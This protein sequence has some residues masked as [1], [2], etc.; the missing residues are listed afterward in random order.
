MWLDGVPGWVRPWIGWVVGM[1]WPQADEAKLFALADALADAAYRVAD[2]TGVTP[3]A[4]DAWDGEAFRAFVTNASARVGERQAEVLARLAAM[5]I[6]L[7]DLGVQVQYTKRMIKLSIALLVFQLATLLP[8]LANPATAGAGIA[9]AGLRARFAREIVVQVAKRLL[10]NIALF[11]GLMGGMDLYVQATQ[12]RRDAIDW[13]QVLTSAGTG[14]LNGVFLTGATWLMPPRR[15]LDLMLASGVAGGLT[16]ATIQ[17]FDDQPFDLMRLLKGVSSGAIGAADAHWASW[18]PHA[19]RPNGDGTLAAGTHGGDDAGPSGGARSGDPAL[20]GDRRDVTGQATFRHPDPAPDPAAARPVPDPGA[21]ARV[22]PDHDPAAR[23]VPEAEVRTT[24]AQHEPQPHASQDHAPRQAQPLTARQDFMVR[25]FREETS[26]GLWFRNQESTDMSVTGDMRRR[27]PLPGHFDVGIRATSDGFSVGGFSRPPADVPPGVHLVPG[28][29]VH[30]S[31]ADLA[32]VLGE[33]RRLAAQPDAALRLFGPHARHDALLLQDLADRTGRAVVAADNGMPYGSAQGYRGPLEGQWHRFEPRPPGGLHESVAGGVR[34]SRT[35]EVEDLRAEVVTFTDGVTAVRF[36]G[37]AADRAE[38]AA[39][40]ARA[41]GMDAP[42]THR[43]GESVYQS[44]GSAELARSAA[45]GIRRTDVYSFG[46][47]MREVVTFNDGTRAIR[48]EYV[49]AADADLHESSALPPFRAANE[50]SVYRA[51]ETVVYETGLLR[52]DFA[53][54]QSM[55]RHQS[56]AQRAQRALHYVLTQAETF[57]PHAVVPDGAGRHLYAVPD[58][59]TEVWAADITSELLWAHPRPDGTLGHFTVGDNLLAP[60]DFAAR[61]DALAALRPEFERLG[62]ADWHDGLMQ[63]YDLLAEHARGATPLLGAADPAASPVHQAPEPRWLQRDPDPADAR[64]AV[65]DVLDGDG[66]R[67]L[68]ETLADRWA[69]PADVARAEAYAQLADQHLAAGLHRQE[70]VHARVPI[71][72][73]PSDMLPGSTVTFRG[74]LEGVTEP[75]HLP[76]MPHSAQLTILGRGHGFVGDISGRPHHALFGPDSRFTVLAVETTSYGAKH[77]YL[78]EHGAFTLP[79]RGA[80]APRVRPELTGELL[81]HATQHRQDTPAGVWYRDPTHEADMEFADSAPEMLPIDGAFYVDAHGDPKALYIGGARLGSEGLAALLLNEP[82]LRPDD[83]IFLGNCEV[84]AGPAP[85]AEA[86][87][88]R[89]GHVVI[90]P[91]SLLAITEAHDRIPSRVPDADLISTLH[92]RG[93]Y[94]IFLPDDPVPGHVWDR[95]RDLVDGPGRDPEPPPAGARGPEPGSIESLINWGQERPAGDPPRPQYEFGQVAAKGTVGAWEPAGLDSARVT[96]T[97]G[98]HAMLA[99]LPS[100]QARDAKML[101]AQLGQELGLNMPSTH[102]VGQSRLLVDW[103]YGDPGQMSWS[104]GAWND[105]VASTDGVL[106]GLLGALVRDEPVLLAALAGEAP[107]M[108]DPAAARRMSGLF[109]RDL[110]SG[111][112]G[113][114]PNPLSPTDAISLQRTLRTMRQDFAAAGLTDMHL[115]MTDSMRQITANAVS[116]Q[117]ALKADSVA[118]PPEISPERLDARGREVAEIAAQL[119]DSAPP[120]AGR[121][122]MDP[123]QRL[124]YN[125]DDIVATRESDLGRVVTFGD[126]S[127]ALELTGRAGDRALEAELTRRALGLDGPAVHRTADGTVYQAHGSDHLRA[128][129]DSGVRQTELVPLISDRTEV[130]TFND[131]TRAIRHEFDGIVKADEFEARAHAAHG[132]RD[133]VPGIYRAAPTVVYEHRIGPWHMTDQERAV[134]HTLRPELDRRALHASLTRA[135]RSTALAS[136]N[137][138]L[139]RLVHGR[140]LLTESDSAALRARYEALRPEF[141]RHGLSAR[142]EEHLRVISRTDPHAPLDLGPLHDRSPLTPDFRDTPW[143]PPDPRVP[144]LPNLLEGSNLRQVNELAV[145]RSDDAALVPAAETMLDRADAELAGRPTS[146]GHVS[147]RVPADWLPRGVR[148]DSEV[149]FH[150]LLE[151]VDNPAFLGDLPDSV[152]LTIR[153]SEYTDVTDL[154]GKPAHTVF[155]TGVRLK[156]LAVQESQGERHLLAVQVPDGR[157]TDSI[158][159]PV[160]R[161]K[162]PLTPDLR[163]HLK[164]HVEPTPAGVWLRDLDDP[165]DRGIATSAENVVPIDGAFYVDGHGSELG[166]QIGD[167]TL[168]GKQVAALLLH[169]EGL[170]PRD[171]ILLANCHVGTGRH[172]LSVARHTGHVVIAADSAIHVS[173]DGHMRAVSSELGNL[174]GRGQLRIYLPDDPVSGKVADTLKVWFQAPEN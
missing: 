47:E 23:A 39:L 53:D 103:V 60:A 27:Q 14:A 54:L 49:Y 74:L 147:A 18:N 150:G 75:T 83:V 2:G 135:D 63:R 102:P 157:S 139:E 88:K 101:L 45:T 111:Q 99:D 144:A 12:N 28:R 146:A 62:R 3:P 92:E 140:A 51:S 98:S 173:E 64:R 131:G 115:R 24:L 57:A 129:L 40:V 52:T 78:V 159:I 153:A 104:G 59:L 9:A 58:R 168:D 43:A 145:G 91:D 94:R 77:Y 44:H 95:V 38:A 36:T 126:R 16:D 106:T 96:L 143:R 56:D 116:T 117:S 7:N 113:W 37:E 130:V 121:P 108:P 50:G 171:V 134:P 69:D 87:A 97:D 31:A 42:P 142:Y 149:V 32:A 41:L 118:A 17:A 112:E 148:P 19:G 136:E 29:D 169:S 48:A 33:D 125:L 65:A 170:S 110:G 123:A 55:V 34:H 61:R 21:A 46:D 132:I 70:S 161:M 137:P 79:E 105:T 155:R 128:A 76:D 172:P 10:F 80:A 89:T 81:R 93:R 120:G 4:G 8:F 20:S 1:D 151:G 166:N 100:R 13:H 127:Q 85:L 154:S 71:D 30:I 22:T 138:R 119:R 67:R 84:G 35:L 86:L 73:L 15:L 160:P 152:R 11:G 163:H 72:R 156:V 174:G 107:L 114:A 25:Q 82:R 122:L 6:A 124:A 141:E 68:N 26:S 162:P 164:E 5:A 165:H 167:R 158:A 90:A 66:L 109:I 133:G